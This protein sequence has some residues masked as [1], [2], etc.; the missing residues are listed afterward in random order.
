MVSSSNSNKNFSSSHFGNF[1]HFEKGDFKHKFDQNFYL[2]ILELGGWWDKPGTLALL[3]SVNGTTSVRREQ[4]PGQ[5][6]TLSGSEHVLNQ[7]T[8]KKEIHQFLH[9]VIFQPIY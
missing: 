5:D 7:K 3:T 1:V 4:R 9:F 8:K 6:T 2:S